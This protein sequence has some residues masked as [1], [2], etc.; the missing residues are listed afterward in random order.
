[1]D[2]L[3]L[4]ATGLLSIPIQSPGLRERTN[5][6]YLQRFSFPYGNEKQK[7]DGGTTCAKRTLRMRGQANRLLNER[8]LPVLGDFARPIP[9]TF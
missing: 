3:G 9:T 8:G 5:S 2:Y 7:N 4:L 6:L 1:L